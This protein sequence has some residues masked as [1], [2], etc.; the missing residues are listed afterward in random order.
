MA[1]A[2][3]EA[4]GTGVA[5]K[6]MTGTIGAVAAEKVAA[7]IGEVG[8][9]VIAT[10]DMTIVVEAEADTSAMTTVIEMVTRKAAAAVNIIMIAVVGKV[11]AI[12]QVAKTILRE[13]GNM[14]AVQ[15]QKERETREIVM[16]QGQAVAV[17][18]QRSYN[19]SKH[20]RR[21]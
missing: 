17:L 4:A 8:V 9:N 14:A 21:K 6:E 5:V 11:K 3:G 10:I 15:N 2:V 16:A 19:A 1:T 7:K 20:S 13:R 18:Q 12:T